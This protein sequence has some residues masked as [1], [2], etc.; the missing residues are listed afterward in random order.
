MMTAPL[1]DELK[2]AT[3]WFHK[4]HS[5]FWTVESD[6]AVLGIC[7]FAEANREWQENSGMND[8]ALNCNC[9]EG[10]DLS[11]V[12]MI[13][14]LQTTHPHWTTRMAEI[15]VREHEILFGTNY[16]RAPLSSIKEAPS[17]QQPQKL[18]K[19]SDINNPTAMSKPEDDEGIEDQHSSYDRKQRLLHESSSSETGD[20]SS[21]SEATASKRYK[22]AQEKRYQDNKA[23]TERWTSTRLRTRAKRNLLDRTDDG[24]SSVDSALPYRDR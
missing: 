21:G 17:P 23:K 18:F 16:L 1:P 2:Q 6:G 15:I 24:E 3:L 9:T 5:L 19:S 14:H 7:P 12:D 4:C 13:L 22:I 10:Y 20:D 8:I 11:T